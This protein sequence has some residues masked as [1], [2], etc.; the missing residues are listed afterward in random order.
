MFRNT[1]TG[2]QLPVSSYETGS[3]QSVT[4]VNT[5]PSVTCVNP[6]LLVACTLLLWLV[7]PVCVLESWNT[8]N[9]RSSTC[10]LTRNGC[11][12]SWLFTH[13][14]TFIRDLSLFH[15]QPHLYHSVEPTQTTM[16]HCS[17]SLTF[18]K[19]TDSDTTQTH[20]RTVVRGEGRVEGRGGSGRDCL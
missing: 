18:G 9:N 20:R 19:Q 7:C 16:S 15:T 6:F 17:I 14:M 8:W 2:T 11:V 13:R 4:A 3:A 1:A 12:V 5:T 10:V